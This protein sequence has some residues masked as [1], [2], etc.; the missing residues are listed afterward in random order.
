ML[1]IVAV[2]VAL[3]VLG[4]AFYFF[5]AGKKSDALPPPKAEADAQV[6]AKKAE[7]KADKKDEPK[8]LD[9][10]KPEAAKPEAPKPEAPK[11]KGEPA[12]EPKAEP[13]TTEPAKTEPV[14]ETA[15]E[16]KPEVAEPAKPAEPLVE[17]K[18]PSMRPGAAKDAGESVQALKKGLA[19]TRGGFIARLAQL[20][21]RKK[22]IDPAL[23]DEV[24]TVLL[25]ADIGPRTA[26]KMLEGLREEVAR[27]EHA[28]EDAV[29][30]SLRR[31]ATEILGPSRGAIVASGKPTVIVVVGVNGVGKTTTIGKLASRYQEDGKKVVLAAGDTFRAAAVLQLEV[32]G[33]RVGC[34]VVKGKDRA[35]PGAVIF[36][37]IKKGVADGADVVIAD[38]AGRLHTKS[39][40]MEEL[41]KVVRT[42]EKALERPVDEIL[43]VLDATTG[44]N[45]I[46]QAQLFREAIPVNGIVLTKLDGTAKGGVVL[47]VA[48]EHGIPVRYV[49]IGERVEDL[50]AFDA[51]TFVAAL[52]E[53]PEEA[54]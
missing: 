2:V 24:Q 28:G 52:F 6:E 4:A 40:L 51:E 14:V 10:K 30:G 39:N 46:Q 12:A 49:G 3:V 29:W 11:A 47:G 20:F 36:D 17:P 50:R 32:W 19:T 27:G 41:K 45:A 1:V 15:A 44:Q 37:A 48:N 21:G 54:A 7:P 38:T 18:K 43:L 33:K 26:E 13:R 22:E 53:K 25:S 5:Q 31:R 42:A 23:L 9:A 8:K 34:E 35:D 16:A